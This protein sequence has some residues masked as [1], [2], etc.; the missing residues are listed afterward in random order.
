MSI[1][2]SLYKPFFLA[3]K[4]DMDFYDRTKELVKKYNLSLIPF[5]QDLGIKYETFKSARRLN[6]LP[7]ADEAVAIAE[8]LNTTVEYLVTGKEPEIAPDVS[9]ILD[10]IQK[11]ENQVKAL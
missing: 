4:L 9:E 10:T 6:V 7:R 8:A 11:L 3:D 1:K 5:L 2:K